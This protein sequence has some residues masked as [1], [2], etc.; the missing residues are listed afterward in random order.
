MKI[1]VIGSGISG[2]GAAYL[3][4]RKHDVTIYE[5]NNYV[6]GHSRTIEI[7]DDGRSQ[8]VDTG[9]IVFND[10]N[11]PHLFG[12]F[13]D[14]GVP[15]EKSDMSFG[16]SIGREDQKGW[17]EYSSNNLFA[18]SSN[19]K[20]PEFWGM[21]LDVLRFNVQARGYI[22]RDP[23]ISLG[24]CLDQ[25]KMGQWFR[26]YYLLA[27]GAAIWSCPVTTMMEFPAA[28]FLRFF[29]NHGLLNI[30]KRPQWYTVSGGSREYTKR[31]RAALKN[32]VK[33]SCGAVKVREEDGG[34]VVEDATGK[35]ASFD[36]VIFA[37]H[38]DEALAL[39]EEP[40]ENERDL[41]SAFGYQDN[42]IVVHK[43]ARFMPIERGAWA[44]WVYLNDGTKDD[45]P[46]LAL[47]YWMNNLQNF[48]TKEQ[49]LVTLN[50]TQDPPKDKIL[51][52]HE[53]SHPI[54]NEAAV[55][56]QGRIDEINGVRGKQ[57]LWF[58]GAYQ[59]YGFHEDG[60][61]SAVRVAK[62]LGASVP[63]ER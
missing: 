13:D 2:L 30:L 24:E 26:N 4:H 60:L 62:G 16:V 18:Q 45:K 29:K 7:D 10:W 41:L 31:L 20:R 57:A 21:L 46:Q 50:P 28:T 54:F 25:L 11:Y 53:F 52:I 36:H 5:K 40:T 56:S 19:L 33:L 47:S 35:A 6:G 55:R 38:A 49:V 37:C 23:S 22:K 12:L 63:W 9:F 3:L 48:K 58:C 59:R 8:P 51:D 27:M 39:I 34:F 32:D 15:Y 42:R 44:S 61:W 43:D 14:L 1:A 17:L